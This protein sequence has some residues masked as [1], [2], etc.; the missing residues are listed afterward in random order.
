LG[1][2]L[3]E[4]LEFIFNCCRLARGQVQ[5]CAQSRVDQEPVVIISL[6]CNSKCGNPLSVSSQ[7]NLRVPAHDEHLRLIVPVLGDC[8]RPHHVCSMVCELI[9]QL[10]CAP[11]LMFCCHASDP[12][13]DALDFVISVGHQ[14]RITHGKVIEISVALGLPL[15][16]YVETV[17]GDVD[18]LRQLELC[19][20]LPTC[21]HAEDHPKLMS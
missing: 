19:Q 11:S 12:Q 20:D 21:H 14:N 17:V 7:H 5:G 15:T 6:T 10:F 3:Q 8:V 4:V 1:L 13:S 18:H 16:I 9:R 2:L